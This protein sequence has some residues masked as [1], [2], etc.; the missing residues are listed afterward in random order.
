MKYFQKAESK[1][2]YDTTS[3]VGMYL[4]PVLRPA[5]TSAYAPEV[6]SGAWLSDNRNPV[7]RLELTAASI[8]TRPASTQT[9]ATHLAR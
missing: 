1:L 7:D 8:K 4:W 5:L 3:Q 6:K 2:H 9:D